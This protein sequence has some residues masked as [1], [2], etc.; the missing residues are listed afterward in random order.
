[1][2]RIST[3][4]AVVTAV[5]TLGIGGCGTDKPP[6]CDSLEAVQTTMHQIRN[7]NV[8]E[9]GLTQLR[10]DLQQLRRDLQQLR[11]DAE[12][13]FAPQVGVVKT[14]ADQF[15]TSIAAARDKPDAA[16]LSA[17]RTSLGALQTSIQGLRDAMS[18]TC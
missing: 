9:N 11:T 7:A 8:A 2:T 1:M 12:A 17:V 5:A 15:S 6:G 13:Q 14:A 16:T 10:T 3:R 4:I 18:G